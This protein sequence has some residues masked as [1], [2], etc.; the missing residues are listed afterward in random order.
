M[1]E[2]HKKGI[3]YTLYSA[4]IDIVRL[5]GFYKLYPC[6]YFSFKI[7]IIYLFIYLFI[8]IFNF[9]HALIALPNEASVGLHTRFG[10]SPVGIFNNVGYLYYYLIFVSIFIMISFSILLK[11]KMIIKDTNWVSGEM[12]VGI[13]LLYALL[14]TIQRTLFHIFISWYISP[15]ASPPLRLPLCV[16]PSA[17]PPLRLPLSPSPPLP[18]SL[19]F[20]LYIIL[21]YLI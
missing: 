6:S 14:R 4:I 10:F 5:Q 20:F 21:F 11:L 15:S 16:S 1:P 18:L 3:G 2:H 9:R 7:F 12:L 17:S 13:S 8:L 19:S